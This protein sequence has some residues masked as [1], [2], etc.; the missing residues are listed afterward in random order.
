METSS[1]KV[2][3][4]LRCSITNTSHFLNF[5]VLALVSVT[6]LDIRE[7]LKELEKDFEAVPQNHC[8]QDPEKGCAGVERC[9]LLLGT[10]G[11]EVAKDHDLVTHLEVNRFHF[12]Q[13]PL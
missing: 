10:F 7:H 4:I 3:Q 8:D 9:S 6:D 11:D 5:Q 12:W 2:N 1:P 13:L